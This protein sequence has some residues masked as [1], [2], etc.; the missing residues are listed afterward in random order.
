ME[1]LNELG[2]LSLRSDPGAT[3]AFHEAALEIARE[4]GDIAAETHALG[5]LAVISTHHLD[6]DRALDLGERALELARGT[7]DEAVVGRAMD[8]IKLTVWQLGD[9]RRLEE[10]TAE[11]E[12]LWRE[13][14]DLWYLQWTLLESA[15]VPIAAARWE[16][17]EQRLADAIA[18]NRRVHDPLAEVLMLD[19]LCW[20]NRSRGAYEKALSAGQRA[21]T[22]GAEV[23]WEEWAAATLGST[24]LDLGAFDRAAEVLE[25]GLKAGEQIGA[26]NQTVRCL[27]QLAWARL[28]LALRMRRS[29]WPR[30]ARSC[31]TGSP[32][33]RSCSARTP[34]RPSR[35]CYSHAA[36]LS[37]ARPCCAPCL[38][39]HRAPGWREAAATAGLVVGLCLEARGEL[40][41]ARATLREAAELSDESGIP[42]AGWEAHAALARLAD[43]RDEYLAAAAA[44]VERMT[45]GLKDDA[46]GALLR[47]RAKL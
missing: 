18:I 27:G 24:L 20:L 8:S 44:I 16:E 3:A 22:L 42:A 6:F 19:A 10:L 35:E 40:D 26:R 4:L 43:E 46:I 15:F 37:V 36:P 25:R 29:C 7:G 5:R 1:T 39:L 14:G 23:G 12:P 31:S 9:L 30:A 47:Q 41:H 21:V 17:A 45:A 34:T 11:L 28:E 13:R 2:M 38:P 33:V 32:A